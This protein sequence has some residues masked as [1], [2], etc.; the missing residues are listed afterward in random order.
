M[1]LLIF[2]VLG[3]AL[4][5]IGMLLYMGNIIYNL[6]ILTEMENQ[7]TLLKNKKL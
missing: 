3:Y 2:I 1:Y 5:G 6:C 4:M 7:T